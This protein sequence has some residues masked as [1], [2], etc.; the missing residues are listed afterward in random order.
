L[1]KNVKIGLFFH[2]SFS[3]KDHS[4]Q[5]YYCPKCISFTMEEYQP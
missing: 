1:P 4:A 2:R 3:L 5:L